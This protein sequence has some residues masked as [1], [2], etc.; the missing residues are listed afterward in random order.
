[1][2]GVVPHC[3]L[4]P[5]G[6]FQSMI[7]SSSCSQ[8][9]RGA[10]SSQ[11]AVICQAEATALIAAEM[12]ASGSADKTTTS[13]AAALPASTES[14]QRNETPSQRPTAAQLLA[15]AILAA[16]PGT[17]SVFVQCNA[18][19]RRAAY[20][21]RLSVGGSSHGRAPNTAGDGVRRRENH[22]DRANLDGVCRSVNHSNTGDG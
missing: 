9:G 13:L 15:P 7:G 18:N 10:F 20:A 2:K 6:T 16:T 22:S 12:I 1:M 11:G 4:C 17:A 21:A 8:C 3:T 19:G 14:A 5:E